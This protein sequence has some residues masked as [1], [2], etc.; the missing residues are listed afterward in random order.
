MLKRLAEEN[1]SLRETIQE[2]QDGTCQAK[3]EGLLMAQE[4]ALS[5]R[6]QVSSSISL[7]EKYAKAKQYVRDQRHK[8]QN[9]NGAGGQQKSFLSVPPTTPV[10]KEYVPIETRS[11]LATA[12]AKDAGSLNGIV[13]RNGSGGFMCPRPSSVSEE[14][15]SARPN[16]KDTSK[17]VRGGEPGRLKETPIFQ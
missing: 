16:V 9:F 6:W 10:V 12:T 15:A 5:W 3:D 8:K 2:L 7:W 17:E 4:E 14:R 11:C 1:K 13:L